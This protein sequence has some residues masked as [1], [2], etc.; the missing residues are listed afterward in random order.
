MIR[1]KRFI[2][3]W[4]AEGFVK[5]VRGA[6]LEEIAEN[7]LVEFICRSM[8]QVVEGNPSIQH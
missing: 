6:T 8:L 3:L 2:K 1:R 7:Y 5:M 4:I